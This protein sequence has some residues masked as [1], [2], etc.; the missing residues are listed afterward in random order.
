MIYI[1]KRGD[2]LNISPDFGLFIK[3]GR[4]GYATG[5]V[6]EDVAVF[7]NAQWAAHWL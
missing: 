1:T 2:E 3:D 7:S 6:R 4:G 5:W